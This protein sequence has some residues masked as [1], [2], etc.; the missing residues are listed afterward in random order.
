MTSLLTDNIPIIAGSPNGVQ[1]LRELILQLA[2]M[3]KLVPQNPN[4]ES[5]SK[6]LERILRQKEKESAC[7]TK[8]PKAKEGRSAGISQAVGEIPSSWI[9][10]NLDTIA[11]INPRNSV[12]DEISASFVPMAM[13]GTT[14]SGKH[15]SDQRLWKEI[16]QGFTHFGEGDIGIAKITPCFENS[17]ACVF[18]GLLNGV[19][20]G[21]TELHIVRPIPNTLNPRYVL[22]Y[23]KS[24]M[25]LKVG[26]RKMTGTAGQKRL[27]KDFVQ[28]N[29]FPLPPL[30]EQDRIVKKL[31]ELMGLCDELESQQ[32]QAA[33]AHSIL[34]KTSLDLLVRT[35]RQEEFT[36]RWN[37]IAQNFDIV[38]SSDS[39]VNELRQTIL[40]LAVMGKLVLPEQFKNKE[41]MDVVIQRLRKRKAQLLQDKTIKK[42]LDFSP[43]VIADE[44]RIWLPDDWT[45]VNLASLSLKIT[46]G[47][48]QTPRR[49]KEGFYLL[50]ARNVTNDGIVLD[51]VD[52][53]DQ[54]EFEKLRK[55]CDP[56]I[57]D[58]LI[59]CSGSVGRVA[60]VDRNHS[61]VMVRSAAMVRVL[62]DFVDPSYLQLALQS[63]F[64]QRQIERR[65]KSTAQAN[66]FLGEIKQIVIPYPRIEMQRD[67]VLRVRELFLLTDGLSQTLAKESDV[68]QKLGSAIV[69]QCVR[70]QLLIAKDLEQGSIFV[71]PMERTSR[72]T[73]VAGTSADRQPVT[74]R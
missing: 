3:G 14:F 36:T 53:V 31:D 18:E 47:E 30:A 45:Y 39:S 55:R 19:G 61:Y 52:F 4:D 35:K 6:L 44:D 13:I 5:A 73:K 15:D 68:L 1:K 38:F 25:F 8:S 67:I 34:V 50:S 74:G 22:A 23:V 65:S 51:D 42:D 57:G 27:P 11:Y 17:K 28:F 24:P 33:A 40:Q 2:L 32:S 54:E 62:D 66:L 49:T 37:L 7:K 71:S 21:T 9:W 69:D 59:S 63:P 60:L 56:N 41:T 64:C 70:D 72:R 20:A 16:K 48:H 10:T 12:S 58:V 26:E 43:A 46:D 29:P